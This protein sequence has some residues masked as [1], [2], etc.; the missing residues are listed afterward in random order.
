[1]Q[2]GVWTTPGATI[3]LESGGTGAPGVA[4]PLGGTGVMGVSGETAVV[5]G[6]GVGVDV[7]S[8]LGVG[9]EQVG[10]AEDCPSSPILGKGKIKGA[11][12]G[13]S[14]TWTFG[15]SRLIYW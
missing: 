7:G 13:S 9:A 1:M 11:L 6:S 14:I 10:A 4:R 15:D 8:V 12:L 5:T 2:A 3:T